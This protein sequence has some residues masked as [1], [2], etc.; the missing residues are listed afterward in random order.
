MG[1]AV[2]PG[3]G[4]RRVGIRAS[5]LR[6]VDMHFLRYLYDAIEYQA[7]LLKEAFRMEDWIDV[8]SA[9]SFHMLTVVAIS[10]IQNHGV[11]FS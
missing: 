2:A 6:A 7:R 9:A 8:A 10:S 1:K 3:L 5:N 11:P 4:T